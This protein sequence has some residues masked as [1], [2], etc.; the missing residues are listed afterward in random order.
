MLLGSPAR[1]DIR[2]Q[3]ARRNT[4]RIAVL[5]A[6]R[7]VAAVCATGSRWPDLAISWMVGGLAGSAAWRGIRRTGSELR[8]AF[9][10]GA[11]LALQ[12]D[13]AQ[14]HGIAGNRL[15]PA[16]L[17]FDDPAVA[18]EMDGPVI[19]RDK[20]S[21]SADGK[22]LDTTVGASLARLLFPKLAIMA[23]GNW[24]KQDQRGSHSGTGF[25][26]THLSLKGFTL[27][28]RSA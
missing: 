8:G 21:G 11:G 4:G 17:T 24:T 6:V 15:F 1:S 20:H 2:P 3:S 5:A 18:D 16:T 13:S 7:W 26:P 22:V 9:V 12:F 10:S 14:A 25:D 19:S 23:A 27:R 28:E